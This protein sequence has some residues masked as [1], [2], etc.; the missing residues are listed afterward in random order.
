MKHLYSYEA[1]STDRIGTSE[2]AENSKPEQIIMKQFHYGADPGN[3]FHPMVKPPLAV[4]C[5]TLNFR[6]DGEAGEG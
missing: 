3:G 2:I 4:S 5:T 1:A 6:L